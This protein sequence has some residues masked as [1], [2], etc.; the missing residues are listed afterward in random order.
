MKVPADIACKINETH[1]PPYHDNVLTWN[2]FKIHVRRKHEHLHF[3]N[4]ATGNC[5]KASFLDEEGDEV[6]NVDN[7]DFRQILDPDVQRNFLD[8]AYL[9]PIRN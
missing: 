5:P 6:E 7:L 2:A 9:L 4:A 1:N 8:A 3:I